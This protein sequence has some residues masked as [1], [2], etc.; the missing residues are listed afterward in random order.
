MTSKEEH[1]TTITIDDLGPDDPVA[2]KMDS[3]GKEYRHLSEEI[4]LLDTERKLHKQEMEELAKD[5]RLSRVKNVSGDGWQFVKVSGRTTEEVDIMKLL[6]LGVA[7]ELIQ[8]ATVKKKGEDY[9]MVKAA[10]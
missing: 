1:A 9:Y 8:K 2:R 7:A 10:G 5:P 6:D 4:E 3:H